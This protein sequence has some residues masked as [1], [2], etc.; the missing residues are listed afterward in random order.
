MASHSY[1][2]E[3]AKMT[4]SGSVKILPKLNNFLHLDLYFDLD[5]VRPHTLWVLSVTLFI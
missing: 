2:V 5:S 1:H 4:L 3:A